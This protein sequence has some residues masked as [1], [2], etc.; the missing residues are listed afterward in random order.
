MVVQP[1]DQESLR[2]G[3]T[4]QVLLRG[5]STDQVSLRS[6]RVCTQQRADPLLCD[7]GWSMLDLKCVKSLNTLC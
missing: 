5:G 3:S 1:A 7:N 6:D 4:N 2:A